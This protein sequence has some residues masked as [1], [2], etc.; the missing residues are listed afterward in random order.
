MGE[1]D[2]FRTAFIAGCI[3]TEKGETFYTLLPEGLT[4]GS[5]LRKKKP[6]DLVFKTGHYG[7]LRD[8]PLGSALYS[9]EQ[10]P[11]QGGSLARAAGTFVKLVQ[12][13]FTTG[14]ARVKLASKKEVLL[15]LDCSAFLGVV[16][17]AS[18]NLKVSSKAG[19]SRWLG[20]RPKVRGVAMNPV[21]HPH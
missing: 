2:P 4:I 10:V 14:K 16:S 9:V 17:N 15:S 3:N 18:H 11:G 8:F 1:Y 21:D 12:K 13:D 5:S 19:R 6:T 20:F 7:F